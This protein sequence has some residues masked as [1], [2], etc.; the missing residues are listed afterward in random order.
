MPASVQIPL[1]CKAAWRRHG[2][3]IGE[4]MSIAPTLGM[5]PSYRFNVML[6]KDLEFKRP[7]RAFDYIEKCRFSA[8]GYHIQPTT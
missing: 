1:K 8:K 7:Y 3:N 2:G 5:C 6:V 4:N